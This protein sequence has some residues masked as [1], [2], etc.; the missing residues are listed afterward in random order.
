ML[1][2]MTREETLASEF[3]SITVTLPEATATAL[4]LPPP[5]PC[6]FLYYHYTRTAVSK[7]DALLAPVNP[8]PPSEPSTAMELKCLED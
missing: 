1:S 6:L 4:P 2:G 7:Y 8:K 5:F 3:E